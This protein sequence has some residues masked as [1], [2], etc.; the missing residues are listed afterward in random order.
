MQMTPE[1]KETLRDLV[2]A[3]LEVARAALGEVRDRLSDMAVESASLHQ[4]ARRY[5]RDVEYLEE[6]AQE[7][8][9]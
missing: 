2:T 6:L 1:H 5:E 7:L 3:R 4:T 9:R 8:K